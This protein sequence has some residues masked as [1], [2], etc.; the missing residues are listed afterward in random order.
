MAMIQNDLS[1]SGNSEKADMHFLL[2]DLSVTF[3]MI[4]HSILHDCQKDCM[5]WC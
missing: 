2:L 3:Y 5:V 4:E 1:T